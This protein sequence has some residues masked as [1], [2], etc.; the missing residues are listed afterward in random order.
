MAGVARR[1]LVDVRYDVF[2]GGTLGAF[3]RVESPGRLPAV[4]PLRAP[5][6]TD[7]GSMVE[8]QVELQ[9]APALDVLVVDAEARDPLADV[10]GTLHQRGGGLYDAVREF[11]TQDGRFTLHCDR[12][13]GTL[14]LVVTAPGHKRYR[15]ESPVPDGP[16]PAEVIVLLETLE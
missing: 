8:P 14:V 16:R 7:G 13:E 10:S 3:L 1:F 2:E 15:L 11:S 12:P 5:P 9:P 4:V 6:R